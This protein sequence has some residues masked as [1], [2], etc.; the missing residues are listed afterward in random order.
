MWNG[1]GGSCH[2][3][4]RLLHEIVRVISGSGEAA[5]ESE[6][7]RMVAVKQSR[8]AR[9]GVFPLRLDRARHRQRLPGHTHLDARAEG[10][11]GWTRRGE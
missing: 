10:S 2:A 9:R 3:Q 7:A 1:V 6:E 11:V 5:G 8:D 4:E